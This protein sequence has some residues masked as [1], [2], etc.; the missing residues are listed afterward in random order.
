[1]VVAGMNIEQSAIISAACR[2]SMTFPFIF[3]FRLEVYLGRYDTLPLYPGCPKQSTEMPHRGSS[4]KL[5]VKTDAT[6]PEAVKAMFAE[7]HEYS[8]ESY[9]KKVDPRW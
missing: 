4:E 6:S 2:L 7:A 1:M 3:A 9:M 5:A 8:Y